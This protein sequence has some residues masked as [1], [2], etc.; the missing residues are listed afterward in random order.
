MDEE[1]AGILSK[2]ELNVGDKSDLDI[3]YRLGYLPLK[4]QCAYIFAKNARLERRI[5]E[6]EAH[7]GLLF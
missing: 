6:L 7:Q 4:E 1:L 5:A 3:L 2:A